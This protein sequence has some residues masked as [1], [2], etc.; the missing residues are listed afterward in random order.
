MKKWSEMYP[1]GRYVYYEGEDPKSFVKEMIE[2]YNFD[3]S[4]FNEHW[5][6]HRG[7]CFLLPGYCIDEVY[8][9]TKYPLG[10]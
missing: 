7:F 6:I 8:D 3:P 5:N 1:H 10:S 4:K 9:R 2:K